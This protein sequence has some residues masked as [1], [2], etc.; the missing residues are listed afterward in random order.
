LE[1]PATSVRFSKKDPREVRRAMPVRMVNSRSP[2]TEGALEDN[3]AVSVT[4]GQA[5]GCVRPLLGDL[6]EGR[7]G[8]GGPSKRILGDMQPIKKGTV[9]ALAAQ[10][11]PALAR[12]HLLLLAPPDR[13]LADLAHPDPRVRRGSPEDGLRGGR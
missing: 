12:A 8:G 3:G 5:G 2:S 1:G 11:D 9:A 6:A 10:S 4:H 13:L 7:K